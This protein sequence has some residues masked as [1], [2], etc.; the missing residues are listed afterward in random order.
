M[1]RVAE[2][3]FD[4]FVDRARASG[5]SVERDAPMAIH[6]TYQVGGRARAAVKISSSDEL[7]RLAGVLSRSAAMPVVVLGRGSNTLVADEGFDGVVV[8]MAGMGNASD[9]VVVNGAMVTASGSTLLPVLARRSVAAGRCGL[10]W[11]VGVPGTVGGGVAMNAGGHGADIASSLVTVELLSL[12]SGIRA[13]VPAG[14]LDLHFRGSALAPHHVVL[15]ATFST[16]EGDCAQTLSE[17]VAWRRENQPGGRNAGSVF[18]NPAPGEGSAGAMIDTLGLRGLRVG[19]AAVST[20]HANFIVADHDA[21]A[22]DVVAV[23]NAV[24]RAVYE[25]TAVALRSE[26]RLIGFD[27]ETVARFG[28]GVHAGAAHD[29]ARAALAATMGDL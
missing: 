26:V 8:L 3:L 17:I 7:E 23:M 28:Q 14:D 20:K 27:D 13:S 22:A 24:Q 25:S 2:H 4:D 29:G 19:G 9:E 18:V 1:T 16:T 10:E 12:R 15:G 6:T 11:A 21:T 5:L